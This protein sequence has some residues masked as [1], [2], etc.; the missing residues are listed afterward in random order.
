[1]QAISQNWMYAPVND[2]IEIE[3]S[4]MNKG[5][6]RKP[7]PCKQFQKLLLLAFD[8]VFSTAT[9]AFDGILTRFVTAGVH[10]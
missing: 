9:I 10:S 7:D 3:P 2:Q 6:T 4:K 8:G 1:M 5:Q